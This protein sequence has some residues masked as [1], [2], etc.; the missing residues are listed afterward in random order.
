[1]D[2]FGWRLSRDAAAGKAPASGPQALVADLGTRVAKY[3]DD[4]DQGR[5]VYPACTRT[6]DD[7]EGDVRA[8]W[9]HTRLEALR[10]VVAV[11]ARGIELL[12]DPSRQPEMLEAYL[13]QLPH[14]NR[15]IDLTGNTMADLAIAMVAG[16]NWLI[17]CAA[18]ADADRQK[19]TGTLRN[20]RKITMVGQQW[21]ATEG[22]E[23]RCRQ[24]LT[25]NEKP[26]LMLYLIWA[27][28]TRL[29]K[30]VAAAALFGP[31]LDRAVDRRREVLAREFAGRPAELESA[32][33]DLSETM[34]DFAKAGDPDDLLR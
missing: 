11:P 19:F 2:W 33:D 13:R 3:L 6:P 23:A 8:I 28:Y 30:E 17:H 25:Q 9:D 18:L 29:A 10:Y 31:S 5:L 24:M 12:G 27:E 32:L 34:A 20:F 4:V 26:P 21:W 22:A 14:E 16:F 1:M 7:A 15:V